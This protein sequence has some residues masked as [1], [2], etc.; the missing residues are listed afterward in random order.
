MN[1]G[2]IVYDDGPDQ[3][4]CDSCDALLYERKDQSFIC[5]N[6]ECGRIYNPDSVTKH[7]TKLEPNKSP[8]SQEGPELVPITGFTDMKKKKPSVFDRE[9]QKM[10]R[11]GFSIV[12]EWDWPD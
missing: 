9:D 12:E 4:W 1:S 6:P 7:R 10:K 11:P 2:N 8:Y 5:S 3:C